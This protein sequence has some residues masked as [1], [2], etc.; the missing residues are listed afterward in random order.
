MKRTKAPSVEISINTAYQQW[1]VDVNF[2]L[3]LPF[4]SAVHILSVATR[5]ST[6]R[7]PR[8]KSEGKPHGRRASQKGES[9][10]RGSLTEGGASR[11][12]SLTECE[13]HGR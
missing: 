13:P 11:K 8:F 2:I 3:D 5:T 1:S 9:H 4:P 6:E 12:E 7:I 10:R